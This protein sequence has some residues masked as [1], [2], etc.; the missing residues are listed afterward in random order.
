MIEYVISI[1]V[2]FL[3]W[4]AINTKEELQRIRS[5]LRY[6]SEQLESLRRILE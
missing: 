5:E 2:L 3:I 1:A 4:V 6:L